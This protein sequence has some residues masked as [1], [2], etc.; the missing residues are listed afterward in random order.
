MAGCTGGVALL[1]HRLIA[2]TPA[3]CFP[4][5]YRNK[6]VVIRAVL[7]SPQT[8]FL[9]SLFGMKMGYDRITV[10][11]EKM[12]GQPCIRGMRITVRRVLDIL[13]TYPKREDLYADY[14]ELEEED[15]QQALRFAAANLDDDFQKKELD[16]RLDDLKKNPTEGQPWEE[17]R[18]EIQNRL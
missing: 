3:A 13:A 2:A 8:L 17:V 7:S 18:A 15:L 11:P 14:P 12:N 1:N 5:K 16:R 10:D 9:G 4:A 6:K